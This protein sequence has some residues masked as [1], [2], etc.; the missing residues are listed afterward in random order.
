MSMVKVTVTAVIVWTTEFMKTAEE[1]ATARVK[2][3][4]NGYDDGK[5]GSI[6]VKRTV[7]LIS[8][9]VLSMLTVKMTVTGSAKA[10]LKSML[11]VL[12]QATEETISKAK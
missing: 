8:A 11:T 7:I 4:G 2:N 12:D 9:M 1:L 3:G 10:E 5:V 6:A